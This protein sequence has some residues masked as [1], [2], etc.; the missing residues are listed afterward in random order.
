MKGPF[1]IIAPCA[2]QDTG[3][4]HKRGDI[5]DE[6]STV[7][8]GRLLAFGCIMRKEKGEQGVKKKESIKVKIPKGS[9]KSLSTKHPAT[10]KATERRPTEKRALIR[11]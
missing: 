3:T 4:R 11:D 5:I 6:L 1:I 8:Y 7:E 9:K 10:E 2:N